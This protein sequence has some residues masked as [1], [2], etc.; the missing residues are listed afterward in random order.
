MVREGAGGRGTLYAAALHQRE[1]GA[2]GGYQRQLAQGEGAV[3]KNE[4][5]KDDKLQRDGHGGL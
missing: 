4:N 1:H 5:G 2:A 3:Q